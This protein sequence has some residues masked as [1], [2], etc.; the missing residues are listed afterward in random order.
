MNSP[1]D[2]TW[3]VFSQNTAATHDVVSAVSNKRIKICGVVLVAAGAVGIQ[4]K[5]GSVSPVS[6][7]PNFPIGANGGFVLPTSRDGYAEPTAVGKKLTLTLDAA[8]QVSGL[9]GY[10]LLN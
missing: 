7:T 4:F 6:L 1:N 5:D 10:M 3:V 8:V 2:I 9:I